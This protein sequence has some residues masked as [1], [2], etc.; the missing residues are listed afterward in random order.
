MIET[1]AATGFTQIPE[2]LSRGG[3]PEACLKGTGCGGDVRAA[4]LSLEVETLKRERA[5]DQELGET[6]KD[7]LA[8]M[9]KARG[10]PLSDDEKRRAWRSCAASAAISPPA[11]IRAARRRWR[12]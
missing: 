2:Q 7:Y 1:T 12:A 4:A 6:A 3:A 9:E 5:R 11:M 8:A 10:R